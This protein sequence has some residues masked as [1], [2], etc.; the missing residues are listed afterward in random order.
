MK[1]PSPIHYFVA[2]EWPSKL[3]LMVIPLGFVLW[4]VRSCWPLLLRPS[5]WPDPLLFIGCCLLAAL[6]GYFVGILIGWPILGPF[7]YSRSLKNGEPFQQGEMV[8]V[9]V[10]PFRDR[11]VR[12]LDS[13]DIAPWAG[14]HRIRVDLGTETKD[15]ENIFSSIQILRVSNS[16]LPT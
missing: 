4:V 13:F 9:L 12:V 5:G 8:H 7:Y 2:N 1:K 16:Q 11:V 6:L 10:G 3:W 15:D 14:A